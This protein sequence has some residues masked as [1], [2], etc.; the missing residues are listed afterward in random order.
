[1]KVLLS[2]VVILQRFFQMFYGPI[3][4]SRLFDTCPHTTRLY[5]NYLNLLDMFHSNQAKRQTH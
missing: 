1:M 2:W 5:A 3:P 4:L